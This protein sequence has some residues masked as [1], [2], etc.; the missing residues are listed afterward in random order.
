MN[1]YRTAVLAAASLP[2]RD[3]AGGM[4][5]DHHREPSIK[6]S[7]G[8]QHGQRKSGPIGSFPVPPGA[9]LINDGTDNGHYNIVFNSVSPSREAT[10]F[11]TTALPQA[12]YTIT[13]NSS[14]AGEVLQRH[15]DLV[16]RSRIQRPDRGT[17]QLPHPRYQPRRGHRRSP[18]PRS[19]HGRT[20]PRRGHELLLI[21]AEPH[22]VRCKKAGEPDPENAGAISNTTL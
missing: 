3:I 6:P 12:G 20:P 10:R 2:G 7:A 15:R 21:P 16:H 1:H 18:S 11:Y 22:P 9:R 17:V 13:S 14:A 4:H 5:R 8:K 19:S